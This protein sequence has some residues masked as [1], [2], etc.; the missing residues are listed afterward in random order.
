[1]SNIASAFQFPRSRWQA[2]VQA[3]FLDVPYVLDSLWRRSE[4]NRN[5]LGVLNIE[6]AGTFVPRALFETPF[7][8][9]FSA[10]MV[11]FGFGPRSLK[12]TML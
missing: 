2:V 9:L 4:F 10:L 11:F 8:I 3:V 7:A 6:G 12:P 1:M 5:R